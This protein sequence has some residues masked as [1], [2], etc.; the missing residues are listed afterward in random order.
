[1]RT[2][3]TE[4]D[5]DGQLVDYKAKGSTVELAGMETVEDRNTYKLKLTLKNGRSLYVW[6]DA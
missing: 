5:L 3:S 4:A 2:T 1:M 6:I